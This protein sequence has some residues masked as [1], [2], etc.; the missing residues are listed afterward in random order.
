MSSPLQYDWRSLAN[1]RGLQSQHVALRQAVTLL[2][3]ASV[4][5]HACL[6]V[7]QDHSQACNLVPC[8]SSVPSRVPTAPAARCS[9]SASMRRTTG[10]ACSSLKRHLRRLPRP[11]KRPPFGVQPRRAACSHQLQHHL[12]LLRPKKQ[13]LP[14]LLRMQP[15]Q[16]LCLR[17]CSCSWESASECS[18]SRADQSACLCP[19]SPDLRLSRTSHLR[20]LCGLVPAG[21][22]QASESAMPDT[23]MPDG[24]MPDLE[25]LHKFPPGPVSQ[26]SR[27]LFP[28]A[29]PPLRP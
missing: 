25:D 10:S 29:P 26:V 2:W 5:W 20:P 8:R 22:L 19:A 14:C 4:F 16:V 17:H 27:P 28:A 18:C 11:Q 7:R 21:G 15:H 23:A 1:S 9:C 13:Q 12:L 6:P 3:V 24:T